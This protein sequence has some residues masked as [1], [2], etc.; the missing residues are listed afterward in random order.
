[1]SGIYDRHSSLNGQRNPKWAHYG[2]RHAATQ[3]LFGILGLAFIT[4]AAIQL[5]FPKFPPPTSVGP[6]TITLLYLMVIVFVS[7]RSGF[8]ASVAVSLIAVCCLNYFILPLVPSLKVKNPLDIVATAAFLI[9]AWVITGMAA[10]VRRL[11]DAKLTLRFQASKRLVNV[12]ETERRHMARE[13]HDQIGQLLTGLRFLLEPNTGLPGEALKA[14]FEQARIIV[15]DLLN[16]VRGLSFDLR[17]ADLDQLGLLP[18]FLALFE[19]YKAQ[20]AV[21]VNFKHQGMERRFSSEVETGA[22]RIV[23]EALTNAAR[24]AGVPE[25]KVRVWTGTNLLN[26]QIEDRGR[27][28]DPEAVRNTA[29]SS[30][31]IGMQERVMLLRGHMTIES[32]LGSGTTITVELPLDETAAT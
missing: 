3:S 4:F 10:R 30:G 6:G 18:A 32:S 21:L 12:Q 13:L 28:F 15:D 20:T 9:T 11:T 17:P 5:D 1:M 27:G 31:L 16:R 8:V 25:I 22:Y 23:Q 29:R 14:R 26:L 19:R 7:H 24:H 2:L